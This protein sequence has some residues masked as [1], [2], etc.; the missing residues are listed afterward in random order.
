M[1]PGRWVQRPR[2][3]LKIRI[4][5]YAS[6]GAYLPE[7]GA[8]NSA[9]LEVPAR[10]TPRQLMDQCQI[11]RRLAHLV[12]LNGIYLAP[13]ERNVSFSEGDTLAVWPPVAG[14]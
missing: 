4:K 2:L 6:L 1:H 11:P 9:E 12:L 13:A 3:R 14:G 5:L 8:N 10:S 7:G